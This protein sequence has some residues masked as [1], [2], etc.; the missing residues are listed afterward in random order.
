MST[1]GANLAFYGAVGRP[2]ASLLPVP[3]MFARLLLACI[4]LIFV[5]S[6]NFS[7][8][9]NK[10][11]VASSPSSFATAPLSPPSGGT[12]AVAASYE[13]ASQLDAEDYDA[14]V[15]FLGFGEDDEDND[16]ES[17]NNNH[18]DINN[19]GI[20]GNSE[21]GFGC[22][23]LRSTCSRFEVEQRACATHNIMRKVMTCNNCQNHLGGSRL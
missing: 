14:L 9:G 19:N 21:E 3:R 22:D 23:P 6:R 13:D 2:S 4:K 5:R 10:E 12:S 18:N 7:I 16:N 11:W 15:G 20:P 1:V 8:T 17:N